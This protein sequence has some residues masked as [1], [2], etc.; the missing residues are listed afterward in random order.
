MAPARP[1]VASRT[2]R[3]VGEPASRMGEPVRCDPVPDGWVM[4]TIASRWL[5]T[6]LIISAFWAALSLALA[7]IQLVMAARIAP[8]RPDSARP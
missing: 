7:L 8:F 2:S 1:A 6:S 4:V 5:L 3:P